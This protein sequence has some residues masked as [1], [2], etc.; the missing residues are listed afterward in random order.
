MNK[1]YQQYN[2][3]CYLRNELL[4]ILSGA[5]P[6]QYGR[7]FSKEKEEFNFLF[8][9][10]DS[11]DVS[12]HYIYY[13]MPLVKEF[14]IIDWKDGFDHDRSSL[15]LQY[16]NEEWKLKKTI[17]T[18]SKPKFNGLAF[19]SQRERIQTEDLISKQKIFPEIIKYFQEVDPNIA[20]KLSR[21]Y[22]LNILKLDI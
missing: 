21:N 8:Q 13:P 20:K 18:R 7:D 12:L 17:V 22:N 19:V 2:K 10:F 1:R 5:L 11:F 15:H 16:W 4:D 14:Y 9:G 6:I 3:D